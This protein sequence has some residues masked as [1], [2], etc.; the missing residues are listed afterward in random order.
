MSYGTK[1]T[2]QYP[3]GTETVDGVEVTKYSNGAEVFSDFDVKP[4]KGR[5]T[6]IAQAEQSITTRWIK[7]RYISGITSKWRV[8]HGN[9]AYNILTAPID[10]GMRH[11]ELFLEL[12]AVE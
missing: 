10:E 12:E 4:P 9:D 8:K 1:I 3:D 7:I 5:S 2:L 6:Y 11:R